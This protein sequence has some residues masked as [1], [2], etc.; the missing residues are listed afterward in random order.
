MNQDDQT[1]VQLLT[2]RRAYHWEMVNHF[3][4]TGNKQK[5]EF[6]TQKA[7]EFSNAIFRLET[8]L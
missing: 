5:V 1:P 4:G 7:L 6:H 2:S 3:E 8:R